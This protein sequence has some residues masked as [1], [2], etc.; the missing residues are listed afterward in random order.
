MQIITPVPAQQ[1]AEVR[2]SRL[3]LAFG[4]L[5][6]PG[7]VYTE[8]MCY[9]EWMKRK[10]KGR[11]GV[12]GEGLSD[13]AQVAPWVEVEGTG[14]DEEGKKGMVAGAMQAWKTRRFQ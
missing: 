10:G 7:W 6:S 8:E 3:V 1:I 14:V 5:E 2:W 12:E 4:A 13:S 11:G 9:G